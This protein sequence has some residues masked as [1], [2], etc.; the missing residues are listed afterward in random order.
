MRSH[1]EFRTWLAFD[2]L[3]DVNK[4]FVSVLNKIRQIHF[5]Q[6]KLG[7]FCPRPAS[8]VYEICDCADYFFNPM[9]WGYKE[10]G[11]LQFFI[12]R[13]WIA[14]T[15]DD[16]G[17]SC[18]HTR[19]IWIKSRAFV[20]SLPFFVPLGFR[21]SNNCFP[22]LPRFTAPPCSTLLTRLVNWNIRSCWWYLIISSWFWLKYYNYSSY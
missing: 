14:P 11:V 8:N 17:E 21:R 1:E 5:T 10:V 6:G 20:P 19:A 22:F 2:Y 16:S 9:M 7:I 18:Q 3:G 13:N 12:L 15:S 4:Y